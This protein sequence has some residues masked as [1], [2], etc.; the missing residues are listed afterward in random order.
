MARVR[1]ALLTPSFSSKS[2][3]GNAIIRNTKGKRCHR[4]AFQEHNSSQEIKNR[5]RR[6]QREWR[7]RE[8]EQKREISRELPEIGLCALTDPF[9]PGKEQAH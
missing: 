8:K 6:E 3:E 4:T 5:T 7:A 9:P 2:L 1:H